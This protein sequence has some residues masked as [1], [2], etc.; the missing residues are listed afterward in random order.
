META[1]L[2]GSFPASVDPWIPELLGHPVTVVRHDDQPE[3]FVSAVRAAAGEHL[4]AHAI[5][6][7]DAPASGP[8][9]RSGAAAIGLLVGS[10]P[11]IEIVLSTAVPST[12]R[13][14]PSV[15]GVGVP[16]RTGPA[17]ALRSRFGRSGDPDAHASSGEAVRFDGIEFRATGPID[18]VGDWAG[19]P[20]PALP[21]DAA[22]RAALGE[23]RLFAVS[24]GAYVPRPR[25]VE[26]LPSRWRFVAER[27]GHCQSLTFPAR[28]SCR[29]CHRSDRIERID[30][31]LH[32]G[33]VLAS[34]VVARG[35]QP[36]E[37]DHQV[38]ESGPYGV[39]LVELAPMARVTLQVADA[40]PGTVRIGD[41]VDTRLR[42]LY[43][44][45]GEWRYGR[46]A[47]PAA[48]SRR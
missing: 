11:G 31:P 15:P 36:T 35:G 6:A 8:D 1:H 20:A 40:P 25:Y 37:F 39:V 14:N 23:A 38:D 30:L 46:K 12:V 29:S 22:R 4:G 48:S 44:M 24:E 17:F 27:C 19:G 42:R 21:F 45:E 5:L 33:T 32:G 47:V 3:G 2:V 16:R 18:W 34:T 28:G 10:G 26:N 13:T 41:R 43:P 9:G 7:V